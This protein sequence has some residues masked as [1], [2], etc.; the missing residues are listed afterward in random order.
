MLDIKTSYYPIFG[1]Y[2]IYERIYIDEGVR[3]YFHDE[4]AFLESKISPFGI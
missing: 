3:I 2:P 4:F 1:N